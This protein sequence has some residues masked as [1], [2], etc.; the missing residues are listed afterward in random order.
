MNKASG[1][2]IQIPE[3]YIKVKIKNL[4]SSKTYFSPSPENYIEGVKHEKEV[5]M[6]YHLK[7]SMHRLRT[8]MAKVSLGMEN[9]NAVVNFKYPLFSLFVLLVSKYSVNHTPSNTIFSF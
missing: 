6:K 4:S 2:Q 9:I 5:Y 8:I 3:P 1:E 7:V